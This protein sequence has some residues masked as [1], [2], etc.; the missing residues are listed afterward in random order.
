[1]QRF[2]RS[3]FLFDHARRARRALC[4]GCLRHCNPRDLHHDWLRAKPRRTCANLA[5]TYVLGDWRGD[6]WRA[7]GRLVWNVFPAT[8]ATQ[9]GALISR[10]MPL[11]KSQ[12]SAV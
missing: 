8:T 12:I 1:Y 5:A 2:M 4:N 3:H 6:L 7:L 10:T 11:F 9:L